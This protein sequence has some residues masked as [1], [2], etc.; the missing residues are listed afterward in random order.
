[1]CLSKIKFVNIK[2]NLDFT[3]LK[4]KSNH[5][6]IYT[7]Q[8]DDI[9]VFYDKKKVTLIQQYISLCIENKKMSL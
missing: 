2:C 7:K 9:G 6:G 1:M 3:Y 8:T 5:V 4:K